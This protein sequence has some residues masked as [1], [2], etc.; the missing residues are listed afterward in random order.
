MCVWPLFVMSR[1]VAKFTSSVLLVGA[2]LVIGAGP[3][4]RSSAP[5]KLVV[6]IAVDQ[7]RGDY[8]D[9]YGANWTAGLHRLFTK[10]A[11]FS[12][13]AYPYA[14]TVTCVGHTTIGTGAFPRTHGMIGNAFFDRALGRRVSCTDDPSAR[15]VLAGG[16][17]SNEHQ[18]PHYLM[19]TSFA[20]ELRRQSATPPRIIAFSLKADA[21]IGLIGHGGDS[22]IAVWRD[23]SGAWA[24]STAYA[25]K[26]WPEVDDYVAA[27][28]M[29]SQLPQS[30]T[31]SLPDR[32]YKFDDDAPGEP[33][34]RTFP[35]AIDTASAWGRSPFSDAYLADM[36][37]SLA[38]RLSLGT[39]NA[40]DMIAVSFSALDLVGHAFG[41]RSHEVQDVLA[42]LDVTLGHFFDRL[43]ARVGAGNYVVALSADHGV[44]TMPEQITDAEAGRV[45]SGD[46]G[47]RIDAAL[48]QALGESVHASPG[49]ELSFN[50]DPSVAARLQANPDARRAVSAAALGTP[51]IA[52]IFWSD[53]IA[54]STPAADPLLAALRLSY[55]PGRSG[56]LVVG[57]KPNWI[58]A[59]SGTTHGTF[60]VYDR[61]VPVVLYGAD[62]VPGVYL[63]AASPA[64]IAPTLASL[65]NVTLAH[66]DGHALSQAVKR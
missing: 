7:F 46:L 12:H 60:N 53:E 9:W 38:E 25:T 63:D 57:L 3:A 43:D 47:R 40:T 58:A 30:W 49:A 14:S 15:A 11:Y 27:H 66:P 13:A 17:A 2:T 56:D 55:V 41:P 26:M 24:T 28:S 34:P 44:A 39:R 33:A 4:A 22:T 65:T 32:A 8:V 10:G 37:G 21:V 16:G 54:A 20:D 1:R 45:P 29:A 52:E 59:G 50:L 6:L 35:H 18:G 48:S 5:P 36:A 19:T 61:G 51:G 62:I 23:G 31:R 64:D 42:R